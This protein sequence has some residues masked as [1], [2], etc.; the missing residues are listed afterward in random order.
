MNDLL[1]RQAWHFLQER[2]DA[3]FID[4]RSETEF[5]FVGHPVG[6]TNIPWAD[7]PDWVINPEFAG[8]VRALAGA[9]GESR[10][11]VLICR[12]GNRSADAGRTLES[13]GFLE[14]HNV[15]HG[16]EGDL[17]DSLHRNTLNGWRREGLPWEQG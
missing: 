6:A 17:D 8:Q 4:V 16:F 3:L 12:S 7:G 10:P 11:V 1:P 2:P 15:V 14:V 13:E 9:G 5:W